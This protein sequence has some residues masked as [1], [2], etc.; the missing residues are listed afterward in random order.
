ML[1]AAAAISAGCVA[2]SDGATGPALEQ[3]FS[4]GIGQSVVVKAAPIEVGV[5]G[6]IADSRCA[7]GE[8]CV[9]EGDALVRVWLR[10]LG[11][12]RTEQELHTAV[13]KPHTMSLEGYT[14]RLVALAP[15]PVSG[16]SISPST[17][18]VTLKVKRGTDDDEDPQGRP[19]Y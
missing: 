5:V 2:R 6:V 18:I 14:L 7:K 8:T 15:L 9:W 1:V 3:A 10:K 17:Y 19:L 12:A 16:R 13:R 4:L 11:G